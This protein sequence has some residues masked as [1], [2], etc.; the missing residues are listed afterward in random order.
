MEVLQ[1][2]VINARQIW[3][4][5]SKIFA[6]KVLQNRMMHVAI[7]RTKHLIIQNIIQ[8]PIK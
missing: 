8:N 7:P 4:H 1:K 2:M 3:S 5:F 6:G